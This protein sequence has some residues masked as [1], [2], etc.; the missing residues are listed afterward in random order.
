MAN[1]T[2]IGKRQTRNRRYAEGKY[3]GH[4]HA[5]N[6]TPGRYGW[7]FTALCGEQTHEDD[8]RR[9]ATSTLTVTCKKCLKAMTNN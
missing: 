4:N 8:T 1:F 6:F 2:H 3:E 9:I 5:V 7:D